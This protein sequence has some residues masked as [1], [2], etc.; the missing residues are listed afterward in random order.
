VVSDVQAVVEALGLDRFAMLAWLG[1][2]PFAVTYASRHGSR[3]SHL[4]LHAAYLRGWLKRDVGAG[5]RSAVDA[6]VEQVA[7]GWDIKDPIVR[8][9]ITSSF[10]PESTPAQQAWFDEALRASSFGTD[11]ARRLRTRLNS[12]VRDLAPRVACPTIV[13]NSEGDTNPPFAEGRLAASLIPGAHFVSLPSRNHVVLPHEAAWS[14]WVAEVE[15]FL[16]A[17]AL[18]GSAFA[19]LSTRERDLAMLISEGLDNAQI[20]ARLSIS[21]KT[22]RNHI[23]RIFAKLNVA[24]RAQA[25]VLA[26]NA[27]L[28]R[29]P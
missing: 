16:E 11:A 6:L 12:D 17:R 1:G 23:T 25:I 18:P 28:G 27:G 22:V 4:V 29:T 20:A 15:A 3:L 26:H 19:K 8:R 9:A 21:E 24:T 13:L 10:I 5:E 7:G 2:T 14:R